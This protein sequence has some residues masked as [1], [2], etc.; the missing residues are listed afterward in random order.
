[1]ENSILESSLYFHSDIFNLQFRIQLAIE[2]HC[3][4]SKP[5]F[6]CC[7]WTNISFPYLL[8][9]HDIAICLLSQI[10]LT[11]FFLFSILTLYPLNY[12]IHLSNGTKQETQL[13]RVYPHAV[14]IS[15]LF[16]DNHFQMIPLHLPF[17]SSYYFPQS[18]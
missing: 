4:G 3:C 15:P 6:T 18:S 11:S 16:C 8:F 14:F 2:K 13:S 1:M 9:H 5:S 17:P 10:I 12:S 7:S